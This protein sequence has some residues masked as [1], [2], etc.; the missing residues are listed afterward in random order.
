MIVIV[1]GTNREGS[2][3]RKVSG[4]IESMYSEIGEKTELIDLTKVPLEMGGGRAY[5]GP[6][7]P[8]LQDYI[9][10]INRA[11]G[12]VIVCPE[13]NG[14]FPG[15]LKYFIDHWKYPVSFEFRPVAFVG[16][17][18][19]YGG[20]RPVEHLQQVFAYRNS[21]FFPLR[22]FLFNIGDQLKDDTLSEESMALLKDQTA[23]FSK[24]IRALKSEGLDANSVLAK[25]KK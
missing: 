21:Y 14:S 19:R 13:Y 2:R 16:L 8:E 24:F 5:G 6:H 18:F 3:T 1:S 4:L 10:K 17:G 25:A 7:E 11:D 12:V 22:V 20:L 9:D 15:A 23:G